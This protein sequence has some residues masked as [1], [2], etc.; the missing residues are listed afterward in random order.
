MDLRF[1]PYSAGITTIFVLH[2]L[3]S[4]FKNSFVDRNVR[5]II[6]NRNC[7]GFKLNECESVYALEVVRDTLQRV[8]NLN[9]AFDNTT[10]CG[11]RQSHD[12]RDDSWRI[13]I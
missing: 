2:I 12:E 4:T 6:T 10:Q 5:L 3:I 8:D 7:L 13:R 9:K 1:N 11:P